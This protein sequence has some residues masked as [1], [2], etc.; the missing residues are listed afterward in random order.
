MVEENNAWGIV[1][2]VCGILGLVLFIMPYFSIWFS[3]FG[4]IGFGMQKKYNNINGM[5][6]AGLVTGIIGTV[7]SFMILLLLIVALSI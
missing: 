2:L 3:I 1:S 6:I 5:A 4:I 7:I